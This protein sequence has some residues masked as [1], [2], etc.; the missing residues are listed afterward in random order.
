MDTAMN[1]E[2][3]E[4]FVDADEAGKFY[5][6]PGVAFSNWRARANCRHILSARAAAACGDFA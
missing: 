6:F 3:P 4:A 5:H 2:A 1:P